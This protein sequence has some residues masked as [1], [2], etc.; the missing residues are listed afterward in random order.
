M[1]EFTNRQ[2]AQAFRRMGF[3]KSNLQ[4]A[5]NGFS[6]EHPDGKAL[7]SF[8][9]GE[10]MN[11]T[12]SAP[13]EDRLWSFPLGI[14]EE[15]FLEFQDAG[16]PFPWCLKDQRVGQHITNR[17]VL[18]CVARAYGSMCERRAEQNIDPDSIMGIMNNIKSLSDEIKGGE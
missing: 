16:I 1:K 9:K 15:K 18:L 17:E 8:G 13:G 12:C 6:Y 4:L 11:V 14:T 5:R 10:G 3:K 2:M 7:F